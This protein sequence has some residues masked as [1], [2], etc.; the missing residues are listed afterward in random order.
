MTDTDG[1]PTLATL[2]RVRN[3][4]AFSDEPLPEEALGAI[5]EVARWTGSAGNQQPWEFV[6]VQDRQQLAALAGLGPNLDWMAAAP[7]VIALVMAGERPKL[8]GFD[9]GRLAERIL[10]AAEALGLGAGLGWPYGAEALAEARRLLAVPEPKTVRTLIA[11]GRPGGAAPPRPASMPHQPPA[12]ARKPLA[13]LV[14][15]DRYGGERG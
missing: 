14:H 13:D 2:R 11:V 6:V 15:R 5:L 12:E 8:E 7:V 4:R 1:A 10:V 9:E 3:T